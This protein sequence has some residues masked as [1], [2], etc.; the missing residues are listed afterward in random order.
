L[1]RDQ[2]AAN[3]LRLLPMAPEHIYGLASLPPLHGDPFDRV[4]LSQAQTEKLALMSSDSALAA[5]GVELL[6]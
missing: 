1:V 2:Q 5:Y 6:W 4:L 3:G